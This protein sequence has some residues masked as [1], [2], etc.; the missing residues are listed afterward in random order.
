[1]VCVSLFHFLSFVFI[2]VYTLFFW[3]LSLSVAY[4]VSLRSFWIL[5]RQSIDFSIFAAGYLTFFFHSSMVSC[6]LDS[7]DPGSL[8]LVPGHLKESFLFNLCILA[9]RDNGLYQMRA[10]RCLSS[11]FSQLLLFPCGCGGCFELFL[12]S[13]SLSPIRFWESYQVSANQSFSRQ[14]CVKCQD[15]LWI[16]C[17]SPSFLKGMSWTLLLLC[18]MLSHAKCLRV[19]F[20]SSP[21]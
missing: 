5:F 13:V 1:M 17:F 21:V 11:L 4:W 2:Y 3:C 19:T 14:H 10:S 20:F 12:L 9:S 6:F 8:A 18:C 15:F 16:F 7:C